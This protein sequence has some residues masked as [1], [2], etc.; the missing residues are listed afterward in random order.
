MTWEVK[1]E[2]VLIKTVRSGLGRLLAGIFVLLLLSF[3]LSAEFIPYEERLDLQP[4]GAVRT[5]HLEFGKNLSQGPIKIFSITS[6]TQGRDA[7]EIM[8]RL[9]SSISLVTWDRRGD[10]NAWGFG[11]YYERAKPTDY[12]MYQKYVS[13]S[14]LGKEKFEVM[15]MC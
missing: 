1:M 2:G 6:I 11:D 5:P 12:K 9:D 15:L 8:Q 3:Q 10:A 13:S 4:N 14:I 7:T